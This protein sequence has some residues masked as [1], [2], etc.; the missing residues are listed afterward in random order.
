MGSN[1][2][3]SAIVPMLRAAPVRHQHRAKAVG[4]V[5]SPNGESFEDL[6]EGVKQ[7]KLEVKDLNARLEALEAP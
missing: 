1:P 4:S 3:P 7:L 6:K 5:A 2:I